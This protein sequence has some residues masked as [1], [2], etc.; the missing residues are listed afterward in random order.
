MNLE[1]FEIDKQLAKYD[2]M[3]KDMLNELDKEIK[4]EE[5]ILQDS[6]AV[7]DALMANPKVK[8]EIDG[9]AFLIAMKVVPKL[10]KKVHIVTKDIIEVPVDHIFLIIA[11]IHKYN[12][13]GG[14]YKPY[15]V[16][17]AI[18]ENYNMRDNLKTVVEGFIRHITG[19]IKPEILE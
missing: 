11:D 1:Q 16:E 12:L 6:L 14:K 5:E 2:S 15:T 18:D 4:A 9:R 3:E 7:A 13:T 19:N 10:V 8:V 17:A